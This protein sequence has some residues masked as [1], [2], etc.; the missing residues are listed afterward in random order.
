MP[1][2]ILKIMK[3]AYDPIPSNFSSDLASLIHS[4]VN[5]NPD[6]RPSMNEIISLAIMQEPII[7]AQLTVGRVNP[8]DFDW[9]RNTDFTENGDGNTF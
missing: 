4:M 2:L 8:V 9:N 6:K 5:Q 7:E 3:A 1:A